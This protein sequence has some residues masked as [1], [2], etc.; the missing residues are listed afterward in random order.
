M[1]YLG[2]SMI[3]VL[4]EKYK[5]DILNLAKQVEPLFGKMVGIPEFETALSLC[6]EKKTIFGFLDDN[7]C[8]GAIIINREEN[9]IA[10]F[11]VDISYRGN[12]IG[13]KLIE[14]AI[15]FLDNMKPIKVQTFS[16]D[17]EEG[18]SARKLYIKNG[19]RDEKDGGLNPAGISTIIMEKKPQEMG[20]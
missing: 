1:R 11:V 2:V 18:K 17:I 15:K 14:V 3:T 10:W 5:N 9:E 19:F 20:N 16:K 8:K 12:G 6:F 4:D 7:K 13:Q